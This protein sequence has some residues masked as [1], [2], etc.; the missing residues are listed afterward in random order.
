MV[1]NCDR[2]LIQT[3]IGKSAKL[4]RYEEGN[5]QLRQN[6]I[7]RICMQNSMELVLEQLM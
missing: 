6:S 5:E 4:R 1:R 3:M 2:V 7:R